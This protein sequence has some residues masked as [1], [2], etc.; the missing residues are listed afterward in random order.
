MT[1]MVSY[2]TNKVVSLVPLLIITD[3]P[4]DI[5]NGIKEET[6]EAA[7]DVVPQQIRW[8]EDR[9]QNM[10]E[11]LPTLNYQPMNLHYE[12]LYWKDTKHCIIIIIIA[13]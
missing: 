4:Y 6:T 11:S 3:A 1:T 9:K 12:H 8:Y 5:H 7:R 13:S 10:D 2:M